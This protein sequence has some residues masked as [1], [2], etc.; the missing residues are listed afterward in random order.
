MECS[1][2]API[3][4]DGAHGLVGEE[5]CDRAAVTVGGRGYAILLYTGDGAPAEYGRA[6]FEEVLATVD[7]RPEDAAD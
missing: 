2:S 5:G 7:L 1:S 6:W 4:V 3:T